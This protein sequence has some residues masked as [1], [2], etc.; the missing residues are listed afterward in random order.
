MPSRFYPTPSKCLK[1]KEKNYKKKFS[2][3][4]FTDFHQRIRDNYEQ[5]KRNDKRGRA[6]EIRLDEKYK[7]PAEYKKM[8]ADF[9]RWAQ[10]PD[11]RDLVGH[12]RTLAR[13][14]NE[15]LTGTY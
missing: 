9:E 6:L 14:A 11:M 5:V 1:I 15:L 12:S 3:E 7:T 2:L 4:K 13:K 8:L 10:M